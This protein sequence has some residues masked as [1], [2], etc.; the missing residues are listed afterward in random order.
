MKENADF[1]ALVNKNFKISKKY[2]KKKEKEEKNKK[3]GF[4]LS[5]KNFTYI[6]YTVKYY[7]AFFN[8]IKSALYRAWIINSG[9]DIYVIN[10]SVGFVRIRD[11]GFNKY[12]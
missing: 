11:L 12:V 2:K 9:S 6:T 8:I 3:E 5:E 10:Y 4:I 1:K 7:V